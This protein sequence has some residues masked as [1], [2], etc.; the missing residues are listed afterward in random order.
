[1]S[2]P[3]GDLCLHPPAP[4][5]G[6]WVCEDRVRIVHIISAPSKM[7]QVHLESK[8]EV[9]LDPLCQCVLT[10]G[11]FAKKKEWPACCLVCRLRLA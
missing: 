1:M 3:D 8:N 7:E 2:R 10:G 6:T 9:C 4:Y 5:R 11:R